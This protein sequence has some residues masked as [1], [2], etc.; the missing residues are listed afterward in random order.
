MSPKINPTDSF[1]LLFNR[2]MPKTMKID[3]KPIEKEINYGPTL[4]KLFKELKVIKREVK[5]I[6]YG[7]SL[8]KLFVV[9]RVKKEEDI[10]VG[11]GVGLIIG[12]E[13]T[14]MM[15]EGVVTDAEADA[16]SMKREKFR[17]MEHV[18]E[19]EIYDSDLELSDSDSE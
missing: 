13:E 12:K 3:Q 7:P 9:K 15:A 1:I 8:A 16:E 10:P 19:I 14:S 6:N 2:E 17:Q 5:D 11:A 4:A 18:C